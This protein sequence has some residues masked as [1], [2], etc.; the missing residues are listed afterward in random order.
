MGDQKWHVRV[1]KLE[2]AKRKANNDKTD[3]KN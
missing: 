2:R 1:E 3:H